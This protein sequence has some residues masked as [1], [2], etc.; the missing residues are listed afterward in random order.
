ME[1][2]REWEVHKTEQSATVVAALEA[3]MGMG[4]MP[5]GPRELIAQIGIESNR[6]INCPKNDLLRRG[7]GT[8]G[9][10]NLV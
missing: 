3:K 6:L 2:V 8:S 1:D 4:R 9:A 7:G 10:G 5:T